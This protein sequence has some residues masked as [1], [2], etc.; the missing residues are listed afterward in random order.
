MKCVRCQKELPDGVIYCKF[1][2]QKQDI[3]EEAPL[4]L[5]EDFQDAKGTI[6]DSIQPSLTF[7]EPSFQ[8]NDPQEAEKVFTL[9]DNVSELDWAS[10]EPAQTHIDLPQDEEKTIKNSFCNA[11]SFSNSNQ[12]RENEPG[13]TS[14]KGA[15]SISQQSLDGT[16]TPERNAVHVVIDPPFPF[17]D[18]DQTSP[19]PG[20]DQQP[21]GTEE[22]PL[23]QVQPFT[24]A[25]AKAQP[26]I[27]SIPGNG[28]SFQEKDITHDFSSPNKPMQGASSKQTKDDVSRVR[29]GY[30]KPTL[31][32]VSWRIAL[33][34][35]E[36]EAIIYLYIRLF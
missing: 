29:N 8:A 26:S 28:G 11:S 36:I 20:A 7:V 18:L 21:K 32:A 2:G 19:K 34:I 33:I 15:E 4:F 16:L 31:L 12:Q 25:H 9:A 10:A 35:L 24:G 22:S 23:E 5:H 30:R 13:D 17:F 6:I 27:G 14:L 1:C 3:R